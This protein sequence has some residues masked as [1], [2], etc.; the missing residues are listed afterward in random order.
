MHITELDVSRSTIHEID[1]LLEPYNSTKGQPL[2]TEQLDEYDS[3]V[4]RVHI[5]LTPVAGRTHVAA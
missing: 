4:G 5:N 1:E 2:L 3:C